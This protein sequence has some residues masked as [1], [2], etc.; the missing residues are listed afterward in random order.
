MM[1]LSML[2]REQWNDGGIPYSI[3]RLENFLFTRYARK[4]IVCTVVF[5]NRLC[6]LRNVV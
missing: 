5:K 2:L 4:P 3:V 6:C 1:K